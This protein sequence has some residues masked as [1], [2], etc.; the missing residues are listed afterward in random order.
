MPKSY[1]PV[2]VNVRQPG[3]KTIFHDTDYMRGADS[4]EHAAQI[5]AQLDEHGRTHGY[6]A[7]YVMEVVLP[8]TATLRIHDYYKRGSSSYVVLADADGNRYPMFLG[9]LVTLL[10]EATM[11]DGW[12]T[13]TMYETCKKGSAYGIRR[14]LS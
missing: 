1:G 10:A 13:A 4:R 11:E 2:P 12:I 7:S 14:V 3:S 9:D 6:G 8:F 5:D